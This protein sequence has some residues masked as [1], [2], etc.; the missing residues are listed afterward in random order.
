MC[1]SKLPPIK[2]AGVLPPGADPLPEP[3]MVVL[4]MFGLIAIFWMRHHRIG[5]A[6]RLRPE[7]IPR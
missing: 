5:V 6:I 3:Q 7:T 1:V 4:I 2:Y